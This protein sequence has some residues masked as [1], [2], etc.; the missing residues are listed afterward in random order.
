MAACPPYQWH[1]DGSYQQSPPPPPAPAMYLYSAPQPMYAPP[2]H[3]IPGPLGIWGLCEP[4][5]PT[6]AAAPAQHVQVAVPPCPP[7]Q[8]NKKEDAKKPEAK[9]RDIKKDEKKS[10]ASKTAATVV[11]RHNHRGPPPLMPG[12]SYMFPSA[13]LTL[14]IFKRGS[15]LWLPKYRGQRLEF[16]IFVADTQKTVRQMMEHVIGANAGEGEAKCKGWAATEMIEQ[17]G[18]AFINGTTIE[19]ATDRAKSSFEACGWTSRRG[20]DLPPVW[21][22]IHKI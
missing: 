1:A 22:A 10:E 19:Y 12:A 17:G 16:K 20:E 18:G 15:K 4:A 2:V 13:H 11:H 6:L 21:I 8:G 3:Y 5:I 9:K 14:H 7:P